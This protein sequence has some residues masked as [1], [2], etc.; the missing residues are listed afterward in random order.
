MATD[1][2]LAIFVYMNTNKEIILNISSLYYKLLQI[3]HHE[4]PNLPVILDYFKTSLYPENLQQ[5]PF[6]LNFFINN[7]LAYLKQQSLFLTNFEITQIT[8]TTK[9]QNLLHGAYNFLADLI[10]NNGYF[11]IKTNDLSAF[12]VGNNIAATP[13]KVIF[14]NDLME[15]IHYTSATQQIY[16]IPLLIIPP[17]INKYYVLDLS[18]NNSLV[19]W[20]VQQGFN[21]YIISWNNPGKELAH[22]NFDDYILDGALQ[23]VNFITS[24]NNTSKIHLAGYCIGGTILSC[25]LSYMQQQRDLRVASATLFMSLLDFSN[26]GDLGSF[27]NEPILNIL[28]TL[29]NKK[30]Y[31]DGRLLNMAFNLLKPNELFWPYFIKNYLLNKPLS[32]FDILYWNSD[33][34]NLPAAMYKFY[35]NTICLQNAL[36]KPNYI[37][38]NQTPIN[39]HSITT[40]TFSVGGMKDHITPWQAVYDGAKLYA[41]DSEFILSSSGHVK[42]L[43]N[44]P[45]DNKYYFKINKINK[46]LPKNHQI[47]LKNSIEH[48]GSWWP[49][50]KKWLTNINDEQTTIIPQS[51]INLRNAPGIYV[52]KKQI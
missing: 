11:N 34:T 39:I 1:H 8:K 52:L 47:W 24:F 44:P 27:I 7:Y 9:G 29:I 14:Q 12:T 15:L 46:K 51:K 5:T 41:G 4:F 6:N 2:I 28:E 22:K 48:T 40:P 42:G 43:I 31:L 3:Y 26:L 25:M 23:A 30:G 35:L 19:K 36:C 45:N 37:K 10:A 50:W 20:L 16:K 49:Y 33:S 21:V 32:A 17:C 18:V 38:I 13:G